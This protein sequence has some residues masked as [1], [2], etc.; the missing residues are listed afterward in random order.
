[1]EIKNIKE[2]ICETVCTIQKL[3]GRSVPADFCDTTVPIGDFDGFD[4][5]NSVEVA[6]Q[7]S[8]IL[9]CP[10]NGNP[11]VSGSRPLTI[12]EIAQNILNKIDKKENIK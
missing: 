10:I 9:D 5:L 12:K 2:I 11:F 3:S 8:E 6:A 4:S 7:L 1:M